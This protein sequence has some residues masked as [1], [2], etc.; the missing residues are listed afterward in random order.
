MTLVRSVDSDLL[1]KVF[2]VN[3]KS[4]QMQLNIMRY[5]AIL[6]Y[7]IYFLDFHFEIVHE[8]LF[9]V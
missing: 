6:L 4:L 3:L 9:S 7:L 1:R 2:M 8:K 5:K